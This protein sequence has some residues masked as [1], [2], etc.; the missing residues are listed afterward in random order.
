VCDSIKK[1]TKREKR[2]TEIRVKKREVKYEKH[3]KFIF[4]DKQLNPL[5]LVLIPTHVLNSCNS[6]P[7]QNF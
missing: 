1:K 7:N 6:D 5:N 3:I 4:R 2:G